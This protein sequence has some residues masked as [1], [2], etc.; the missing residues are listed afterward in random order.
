MTPL[1]ALS[2]HV[3]R[4]VADGRVSDEGEVGPVRGDPTEFDVRISGKPLAKSVS[5]IGATHA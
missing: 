2:G 4:E 5:R 3:P 1:V